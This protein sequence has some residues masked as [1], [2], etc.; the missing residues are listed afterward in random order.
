MFRRLI[1]VS[2]LV[3]GPTV[4][5]IAAGPAQAEVT[6]CHTANDS[7][8]ITY[9]YNAAETE[10]AGSTEIDCSGDVVSS[11]DTETQYYLYRQVVC[12]PD[13]P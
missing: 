6:Q 13:Q 1:V 4:G 8:T 5:F 2:A 9:Y 11:G 7:C 10:F 3:A 12:R